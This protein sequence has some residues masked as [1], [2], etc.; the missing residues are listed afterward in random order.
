MVK[1]IYEGCE[2]FFVILVTNKSQIHTIDLRDH[3]HGRGTLFPGKTKAK[4][5]HLPFVFDRVRSSTTTD[6]ENAWKRE[7]KM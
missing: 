4:K 7:W 1:A 5:R 3:L 6:V 2:T